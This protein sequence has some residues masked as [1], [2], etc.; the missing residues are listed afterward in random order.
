MYKILPYHINQ[1]RKLG[2]QIAPSTKG[3]YKLDV[4]TLDGEYITSIGDKRYMDFAL[5]YQ[6]DPVLAEKRREL[7]WKR[8][9]KDNVPNTRGYFL[10]ILW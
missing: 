3:N 10:N 4:Y 1:A 7:Y 9:A 2:V 6:I 8:H 5:Y